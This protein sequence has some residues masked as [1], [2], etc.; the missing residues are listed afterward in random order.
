MA[1]EWNIRARTEACCRCQKSFEAGEACTSS[2]HVEVNEQGVEGVARRDWCAACRGEAKEAISVWQS[3]Y[4]PP[5][6]VAADPAPKQTVEALLRRFME[7]EAH[8]PAVTYVLAVML[9]RK[10]ILIERAVKAQED[11]SLLRVYEHRKTNEIF[12]IADPGLQLNALQP[13]Q[14]QVAALLSRPEGSQSNSA[15]VPVEN[16]ETDF[17]DKR[18]RHADVLAVKAQVRPDVVLVGDSITHLWGG[19]PLLRGSESYAKEAYAET[20]GNRRVLNLGFG[21]DMTQNVLWRITTGKELEGLAPRLAV[22]LIGTNNAT[23]NS[24]GRANTAEEIAEGIVAVHAAMRER[25]PKTHIV[26]MHP[27]P[28]GEKADDP[29]RAILQKTIEALQKTTWDEGTTLLDI[30][31]RLVEADGVIS[32]EIMGDFVHLTEKG[33]RIWGEALQPFL[34]QHCPPPRLHVVGMAGTGMSALAEALI[35]TGA[36]VSGSDRLWDKG[37]GD[38]VRETLE[39]QGIAIFPQDGSGVTDALTAVVVSTAIEET[40]PDIQKARELG[41]PIRHRAEVLAETLSGKRLIAVAGTCGKTTTAAMLGAIL[42]ACGLDPTVVNGASVNQWKYGSGQWSVV[43]GQNEDAT[44]SP[45]GADLCVR[46]GA[47]TGAPLRQPPRLGSVRAGQGMWC[48]AEVD[49]SDRSLLAF[50]PVHA[51]VTNA[52]ADHF[53]QEE[54]AQL[55]EKFCGQLNARGISEQPSVVI[56]GVWSA[57]SMP[58]IRPLREPPRHDASESPVRG[59]ILVENVDKEIESRRDNTN[60]VPSLRDSSVFSRIFYQYAAPNGAGFPKRSIERLAWGSAFDWEG[61]RYEVPMPGKHNALNAWMAIRMALALGC[62]ATKIAAALKAFQGIDRRLER[63]GIRKDGVMVIDDYAHNTEKL[64][65]TW[66]TLAEH[67]P[68]VLALWRP[69][70]YAPLRAMLEPLSTMLAETMRPDDQLYVL[71]VYDAGG[72][73]D[74]TVSADDLVSAASRKGAQVIPVPSHAAA[75]DLLRAEIASGDI[76]AT[77]GARDPDLP[78]T[79]RA[80]LA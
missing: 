18:D 49:E 32:K 66:T 11:G 14:E 58:D 47:H 57:T 12:M 56:D 53:P 27:L 37:D 46:P 31:E 52:S 44:A 10:K 70:G 35:D 28:R 51:I 20:F 74:R 61:V 45:V 72:T 8:D 59:D 55:F 75:L 17:Y 9:E 15:L 30:G 38:T 68:R 13:I 2:L 80:L 69:H 16:L 24:H 7:E 54:A 21:W 64:R 6:P 29:Y 62:E 25:L 77:L 40:N 41:L 71:P 50:H 79:A 22:L 3:P 1:Q 78:R 36:R 23:G 63:V 67:A 33:Y 65:A 73:A 39:H 43:S 5:P 60:D 42:E 26:V 34:R 4:V 19:L 48:V 76:V